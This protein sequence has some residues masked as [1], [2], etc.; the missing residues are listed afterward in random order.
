MEHWLTALRT[1]ELLAATGMVA[2]VIS[3]VKIR[4]LSP[5]PRPSLRRTLGR[6]V[7]VLTARDVEFQAIRTH[8]DQPRPRAH[9]A[10]TVFEEGRLPGS[11]WRIALAVIG[12]GNVGAGV[13]AERAIT[14]FRPAAVLFVGV[15]GALSPEVNLGDVVVATRVYGYHSGRE[16]AGGFLPRMRCWEAPHH[17]EQ[18][19]RQVDRADAWRGRLAAAGDEHGPAVHFQPVAAG[20]VVLDSGL[21]PLARQLRRYC[22]DAA[23]IEME[24]AGVAQAAHL[25]RSVPALVVRGV[26]DRANGDKTR[27]DSA[28]WQRVAAEHAAAFAVTLIATL[29]A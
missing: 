10:G 28:G 19:A 9:P 4:D 15:A 25:N 27:A 29:P 18:L 14:M 8:L 21:S 13:L 16:G 5:Q 12:E 2:T 26:S 23:A 24:S 17:L 3:V 1:V 11:P 20:E 7:V 6:T 22:S